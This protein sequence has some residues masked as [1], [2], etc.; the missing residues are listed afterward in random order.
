VGGIRSSTT[1]WGRPP[2]RSL[3]GR[4]DVW[5]LLTPRLRLQLLPT[6]H[7][8]PALKQTCSLLVL[9][10]NIPRLRPAPGFLVSDTSPLTS[11]KEVQHLCR[12]VPTHCRLRQPRAT[13]LSPLRARR[14][15]VAPTRQRTTME[16]MDADDFDDVRLGL[17]TGIEP[18]QCD[19]S[20]LTGNLELPPNSPSRRRELKK[21][22][23]GSL[24]VSHNQVVI[25]GCGGRMRHHRRLRH[26]KYT[27]E[28]ADAQQSPI[29]N[30]MS[31]NMT[32]AWSADNRTVAGQPG[33][34]GEL[35]AQ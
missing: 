5:F 18:C 14:H 9:S 25:A 29:P 23:T 6:I 16:H 34:D 4:F 27:H 13:I 28:Q 33:Y 20:A 7:F 10:L 26:A 31:R 15:E 12:C 17:A 2:N 21:K 30:A 3:A 1:K 19:P 22:K 8:P 11:T 24:R 32:P 35:S